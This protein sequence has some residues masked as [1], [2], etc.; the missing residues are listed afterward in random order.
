MNYIR[1]TTLFPVLALL[2]LVYP[3]AAHAAVGPGIVLEE[4][5]FAAGKVQEGEV[6]EHIFTFSNEGDKVLNID[7]KSD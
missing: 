5:F 3:Y 7:V 4:R 2:M 1:F 6:I